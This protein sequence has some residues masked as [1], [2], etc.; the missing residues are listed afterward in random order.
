MDSEFFVRQ[1]LGAL[2]E[3]NVQFVGDYPFRVH[4]RRLLR[5]MLLDIHT[6]LTAPEMPGMIR[7][8]FPSPSTEASDAVKSPG[9]LRADELR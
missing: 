1:V 4:N 8:H 2:E 3:C 6:S 5:E 9:H 7:Q